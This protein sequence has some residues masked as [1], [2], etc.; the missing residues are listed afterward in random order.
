MFP[1]VYFKWFRIIVGIYILSN[2]ADLNLINYIPNLLFYKKYYRLLKSDGWVL[3][4]QVLVYYHLH[5]KIVYKFYIT[6]EIVSRSN[7][8]GDLVMWACICIPCTHIV[9]SPPSS[10]VDYSCC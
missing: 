7:Q 4:F 5:T 1:L 8:S 3:E 6:T 2:S 9:S 10:H